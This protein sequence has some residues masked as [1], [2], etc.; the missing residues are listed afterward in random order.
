MFMSKRLYNILD[1]I[2]GLLFYLSL[3]FLCFFLPS[4]L[5]DDVF[6]IYVSLCDIPELL[7]FLIFLSIIYLFSVLAQ[8]FLRLYWKKKISST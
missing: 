8:C 6:S 3:V 7:Y 5:P 2:F 1:F 4:T